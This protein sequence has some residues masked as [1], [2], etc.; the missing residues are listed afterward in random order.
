MMMS[1]NITIPYFEFNSATKDG[2]SKEKADA[3]VATPTLKGR[4]A[5]ILSALA[6]IPS[7]SAA[8]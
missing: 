8:A 6:R 4:T 1:L 7:A 5:F 2:A 3:D